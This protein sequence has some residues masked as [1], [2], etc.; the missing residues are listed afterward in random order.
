[1]TT[2]IDLSQLPAPQ[3]IETLDY[4]TI[5]DERRAYLVSLWPEEQQAEI[6]ARLELE[7]DPLNK[8]LQENAYRELVL[9]QR[10]NDSGRALMLAYAT[11]SDL[12]QLGANPPYRVA[13]RV[14]D[15]GD[16]S[17]VPPRAPVY[18]SDAEYRR[19]IALAPEGYTT[20]GSEM[21]YL[22]HA[23][24]ADA[25]VLDASPV[26]PLPG[27]VTVYVLSRT[28]D[29]S[30]DEALL[31]AVTAALNAESVRPMTDQVNVQSASIVAYT[32]EAALVIYPGPDSGVVLAAAQAAAEAYA[33][34]Q[35]AMRR[36][37]TLSGV[38]AALHQP[39]VMRVD[40][41]QPTANIVIGDGEASYCTAIAITVAGATDV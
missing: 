31:S 18:E 39:G 20:A 34:E 23:L 6:A 29:G 10:I 33:A 5:L 2:A 7:S 32:I 21:S 37:V 35:H 28:G 40:L 16:S 17:A 30:A 38:Y 12:D 19:R 9:R 3:V 36:D 25:D 27:V 13:R 4:E 1:M 11:G 41:A 8:I 22:F 24:G 14:I 26:S 15:Q